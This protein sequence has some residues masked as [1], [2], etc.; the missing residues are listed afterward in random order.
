MATLTTVGYGDIYPI[1][2]GGR[3]LGAIIAIMGI[4]M[5]AIP[6]GIISAGF[7]EMLEKKP[8]DEA[9]KEKKEPY[10]YCPHCGKKL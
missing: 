6:T 7:M 9:T 3:V 10:R 4:G 8:E 5:V 2:T 1:T